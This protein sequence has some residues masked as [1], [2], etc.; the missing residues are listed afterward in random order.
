MTLRPDIYT[1][2]DGMGA[3]EGFHEQDILTVSPAKS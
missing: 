3:C 1:D 2:D